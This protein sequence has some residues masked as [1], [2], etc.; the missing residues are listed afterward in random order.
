MLPPVLLKLII[1]ICTYLSGL[2]LL[3]KSFPFD[4]WLIVSRKWFQGVCIQLCWRDGRR[5]ALTRLERG[6][7]FGCLILP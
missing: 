4:P 2:R 7:R 5:E 3:P 6:A 1:V